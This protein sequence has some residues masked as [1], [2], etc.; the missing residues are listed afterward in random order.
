VIAYAGGQWAHP[1]M[2]YVAESVH[3]DLEDAVAALEHN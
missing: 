2:V 3:A 1:W